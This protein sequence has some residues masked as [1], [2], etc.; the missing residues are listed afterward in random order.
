M[1]LIKAPT[2]REIFSNNLRFYR[3]QNKMTQSELAE[4]VNLTDKYISDLERGLYSTNLD[5]LDELANA[6]GVE[7]YELLK[8]NESYLN[9]INRLDKLTGTRRRKNRN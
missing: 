6:L 1:T 4:K 9:T 2:S 7:S 8:F 3:I 5:T